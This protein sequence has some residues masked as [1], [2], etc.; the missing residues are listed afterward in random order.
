[1]SNL[2]RLKQLLIVIVLLV[3]LVV[4]YARKASAQEL[5]V[6]PT[7]PLFTPAADDEG[8][9]FEFFDNPLDDLVGA[10]RGYELSS[11][12]IRAEDRIA[13]INEQRVR[14]G[15][16]VDDATV[17]SIDKDAVTLSVDGETQVL[18]LYKTSIKTVA[19]S[20]GSKS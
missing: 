3:I 8:G 13:V 11:I 4:F 12:L 6:D 20:D 10:L 5:T 9:L 7:A 14:E 17:I 18:E 15:D 19:G 1:M 16:K 2:G